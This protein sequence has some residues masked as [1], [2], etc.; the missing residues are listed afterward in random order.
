MYETINDQ[1]RNR[2]YHN[3]DIQ[4]LLALK[5]QQVLR[6]EVTPFAAA[7]SLLDAYFRQ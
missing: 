2:F 6:Q 3:K 5:E 7:Q 1:L 4:K